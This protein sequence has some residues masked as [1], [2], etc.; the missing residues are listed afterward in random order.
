MDRTGSR[1]VR[2]KRWDTCEGP[3]VS[4]AGAGV[5]GGTLHAPNGCCSDMCSNDAVGTFSSS[6][7]ISG[8]L[9][10]ILSPNSACRTLLLTLLPTGLLMLSKIA[11]RA[12]SRLELSLVTPNLQPNLPAVSASTLSSVG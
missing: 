10:H 1:F 9:K 4:T 5:S 3:S 2:C 12:S 8:A 7:P 6:H 11:S